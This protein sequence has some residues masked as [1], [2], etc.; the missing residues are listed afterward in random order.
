MPAELVNLLEGLKTRDITG[1]MLCET[2]IEEE[3]ATISEKFVSYV[4]APKEARETIIA[5]K[6]ELAAKFKKIKE[7]AATSFP[8][9]LKQT[10]LNRTVFL[11]IL[12]FINSPRLII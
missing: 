2:K 1:E 5:S 11:H 3:V 8:F 9:Y 12:E 10:L 6:R 4:G 7:Q